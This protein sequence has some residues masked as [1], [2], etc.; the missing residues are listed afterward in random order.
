[1]RH[2]RGEHFV[3]GVLNFDLLVLDELCY[4]LND[5]HN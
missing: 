4:V 3:E 2:R 5:Y 1:M